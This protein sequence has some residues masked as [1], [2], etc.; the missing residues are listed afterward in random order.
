LLRNDYVYCIYIIILEQR[1]GQ[2]EIL[3][4][5]AISESELVFKASRSSGPGGQNVNKLN[6]R[7]ELFFKVAESSSF[8]ETQRK[9]II[10]RLSKR[11]DKDGFLRVV[12]QAQRSQHANRLA[13]MERLQ[14]LLADALK[15]KPVRKKTKVPYSAKQKR[16]DSK[17]HISSLKRQR[18]GKDF[19]S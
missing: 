2:I 5:I 10:S 13:A 3:N 19:E 4:S 11:I 9:Q 16:L 7:I 14:K 15:R 8:S 6:T 17:K 18:S 12:S 1:M